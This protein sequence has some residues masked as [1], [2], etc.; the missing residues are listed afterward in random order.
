[1]DIR[2]QIEALKRGLQSAVTDRQPKKRE[3]DDPPMLLICYRRADTRLIAGRIV[4]RLEAH[5]GKGSVFLD[6]EDT[7]AGV[8]FREHIE[9]VIEQCDVLLALIGPQW[10]G[11]IGTSQPRIFDKTDSVRIE[12]EAALRRN[13]PIIPILIDRSPMPTPQQ[14]PQSLKEFAFRNAVDI[15]PGRDFNIHMGRLLHRLEVIAGGG[16]E[17]P[18]GRRVSERPGLWAIF[19]PDKRNR[20]LVATAMLLA[21][22]SAFV[23]IKVM[24]A[25]VATPRSD[26]PRNQ[27]TAS[28]IQTCNENINLDCLQHGAAYGA[29]EALGHLKQC[30][31]AEIYR[32]DNPSLSWKDVWTTSVYSFAPGGGGPGGGRDDDEL[33]VGGWGDWYFSLI[34]F[35]LPQLPARP[36]FSAIALFSKESE[37]ASVPLALD[38]LIGNWNFPKGDRL[39]WKDRPGQRAISTDPLPAPKRNMW[40]VVELTGVVGEWLDSKSQ[41]YGIQFRPTHDFGSFAVFVSSD[42][43][44][45]TKIPRLIFC[46]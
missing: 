21:A 40:Y 9:L 34:Q 17:H 45:K 11:P 7:P 1:M 14:L 30:K 32:S 46:L 24:L 41:N 4:D 25:L 42:A 12:I 15:D 22:V 38:R 8:D 3:A 27:E 19:D 5:F 43:A 28:S 20:L 33:K 6:I 29:E 39:W 16:K 36:Y 44:D 18:G 35:S 2:V 37:G 13:I 31:N 10:A 26:L 23:A